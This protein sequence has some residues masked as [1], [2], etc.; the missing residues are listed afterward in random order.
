[1]PSSSSPKSCTTEANSCC[2]DSCERRQGVD[3]VVSR[4]GVHSARAVALL[5]AP[6]RGGLRSLPSWLPTMGPD[7]RHLLR[8]LRVPEFRYRDW[9]WSTSPKRPVV[10]SRPFTTVALVSLL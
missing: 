4:G 1:A 10:P 8:L 9:S 6:Y 5:R 7:V 2:A 3:P